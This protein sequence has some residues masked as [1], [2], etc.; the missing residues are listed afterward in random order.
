MC[1]ANHLI[2]ILLTS[3]FFQFSVFA[4]NMT[5]NN[6]ANLIIQNGGKPRLIN[7]RIVE[8]TVNAPLTSVMSNLIAQCNSLEKLNLSRCALSDKLHCGL[9]IPKSVTDRNLSENGVTDRSVNTLSIMSNLQSIDLAW[10]QIGDEPR[11]LEH[12]SR[13]KRLNLEHTRFSDKDLQLLTFCPQLRELDLSETKVTFQ[14]LNSAPLKSL[15]KL[16]LSRINLENIPKNLI[17]NNPQIEEIDLSRNPIHDDAISL[18]ARLTK[19][20]VVNLARTPITGDG[21]RQLAKLA[22]QKV[23]LNGS[24]VTNEGILYLSKITSIVSLDI[25]LTQVSDPGL[26]HL[27][28]LN[29]L[30]LLS[31]GYIPFLEPKQNLLTPNAIVS[32]CKRRKLDTLRINGI[33]LTANELLELKKHVREIHYHSPYERE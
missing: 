24:G 11:F 3:A 12:A 14:G 29:S 4:Q 22:L 32:L 26:T 15:S 8:I 17:R 23:D 6:T 10:T 25:S 13:L 30:K 33:S 27:Y 5:D 7:N 9:N 21:F 31:V 16:V 20:K 1:F 2:A 19:L 18:L 28:K